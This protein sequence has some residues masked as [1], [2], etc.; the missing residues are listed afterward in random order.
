VP[1]DAATGGPGGRKPRLRFPKAARLTQSAE[2]ARV[3]TE[4][5]LGQW[6]PWAWSDAES[7]PADGFFLLWQN[8]RA[9]R[10][11]ACWERL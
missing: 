3:R 9:G 1:D 8:E 10:F 2:F 4:G 6:F 5:T 7:V 11:F